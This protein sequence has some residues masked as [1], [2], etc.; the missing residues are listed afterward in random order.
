MAPKTPSPSLKHISLFAINAKHVKYLEWICLLT[1]VLCL[2]KYYL[3]MYDASNYAR[4]GLLM[5][6]KRAAPGVA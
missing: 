5:L 6:F 4:F 3:N 2:S 1:R